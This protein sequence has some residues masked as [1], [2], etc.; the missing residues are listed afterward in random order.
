MDGFARVAT[1]DEIRTNN[2][3]LN[4]PL[5][6]RP[7]TN[8]GNGKATPAEGIDLQTAIADWQQSLL[9]LRESINHLFAVLQ[10]TGLA[11]E[12]DHGT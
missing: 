4:I 5:Y 9:A 3:N 2:A 11:A 8:G 12:E 1:L 7:M 6:V 10:T